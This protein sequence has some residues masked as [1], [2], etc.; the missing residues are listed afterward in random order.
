MNNKYKKYMEELAAHSLRRGNMLMTFLEGVP[1]FFQ[2]GKNLFM[3]LFLLAAA[4][5]RS[6]SA[7][8]LITTDKPDYSPGQYVIVTGTAWQPGETVRLIFEEYPVIHPADTLMVNADASGNFTDQNYLIE[9]H[10]LGQSF[11]LTATGL[12]SGMISKAYFTDGPPLDLDQ[13]HNGGIGDAPV[14]PVNWVNGNAHS[15]NSHFI[16]GQSI[17]YRFILQN[18][19]VGTHTVTIGWDIRDGGKSAIDYI[20]HYQ[21]I[22]ETVDPTLGL[23]G[24]WGDI[25]LYPI[26]APT[27]TVMV[28]AFYG[29]QPEP[30]YSFNQLPSAERLMTIYNAAIT[31]MSYDPEGDPTLAH[32]ETRLKIIFTVSGS[33]KDV[34]LAWGGH[35]A[36]RLEWGAI[37]AASDINGSPYH[38][39][40]VD[41]DGAGGSQDRSLKTDAVLF[42]PSC[43]VTGPPIVC[44]GSANSYTAITNAPTPTFTWSAIGGTITGSNTNSVVSVIAPASGAYTVN[45]LI[46]DMSGGNAS[47]ST[48]CGISASVSAAPTASAGPDQNKCYEGAN[49]SFTL[50]GS[51]SG[52]ST[53]SVVGG[54]AIIANAS[55][56][57]SAVTVSSASATLQLIAAGSNSNCS[58]ANDEV[59]LTVDPLPLLS[60][61][62][63]GTLTCSNQ[64][65]ALSG[66][67]SAGASVVWSGPGIVSGGNSVNPIINQPGVYK[68]IA[69]FTATGCQDSCSVNITQDIGSA[70]LSCGVGGTL[71][72]SVSSLTL[73]AT[74]G[75]DV[76]VVWNGPGIVSGGNTLNPVI[77]QPGDYKIIATKNS[78]GCKDSCVVHIY[79]DIAGPG[80][81]CGAG[82]TL[83]CGASSMT[84]SATTGSNVSVVW[85]GPGIVSGG[86]TLNPVIN[87]PGDYKIVATKNSSGCKDSCVVHIYQDIAG[88]GLSCGA[89]GTLT[90]GATSMTLSATTGSN[91]SVIWSGPGIVSGGNTLNPVI[92]QP[93]DY[94]IVATKN[95]SGCKD[96]CV[97]HIYQDIAGPALQCGSGGTLTCS[98]TSLTLSATTGSNVSVIWSGPGIVSGGNTLNP[99]IN[100]PG[101]YK[102]IATKNSSGCKDSCVVSVSQNTVQPSCEIHLPAPLPLC[103]STGNTLTAETQNAVSYTWT[104]DGD[105][106]AI[107]GG[108]GTQNIIYTS[109]AGENA[110]FKLVITGANGCKDS[111]LVT[112]STLPCDTPDTFCSLTQGFYGNAKGVACHTGE[113]GDVLINRL[114]GA[115]F[116]DLVIGKP[117]R[118]LTI[119]QAQ[120]A[121]ITMRLPAGGTAT[122]LPSGDQQFTGNCTTTVPLKKGKFNNVLLGQVIT[123]GLNMRFDANLGSL[124][125][126]GTEFTTIGVFEGPDGH[127]GTDDDLPN[128]SSVISRTIPQSVINALNSIYGNAT[129]ANLFDLANRALG[130]QSIG[131]STLNDINQAVSSI[132]EGFD[133]CRM[134]Q[135]WN[136][137]QSPPTAKASMLPMP[138]DIK[139]KAYPNPFDYATT[140]EFTA[141][142]D[143]DITLDVYSIDGKKVA[144]LYNGRV[145]SD[146][147]HK[148]VFNG[149]NLE[150]GIYFYRL[151]MGETIYFEKLM[152]TK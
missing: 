57:N 150:S 109:G 100:Q 82:G 151:T 51:A 56:L 47:E 17:P 130:G 48:T 13:G 98:A 34:L 141:T 46:V 104:V 12:T 42:Y 28:N 60:C 117:G 1:S 123:L 140:I 148:V 41:F 26:P 111:C 2:K 105:G 84:L 25:N 35:I 114:L 120:A 143:S 23:A 112:F 147:T 27:S 135:G 107:T 61:G 37:N 18:V 79:Q 69:T 91:V 129:V 4:F 138:S 53:W 142:T 22:S 44:A 99:V 102:I 70:G 146:E 52:V 30:L 133:G 10:D 3:I 86:N 21:R 58:N 89:G 68:M 92:N 108:Q 81:S 85:S 126:A 80:L 16:E 96:S 125:I 101:T 94:K 67:V 115:P 36:S 73:S 144:T 93:G 5:P 149:N 76:A 6:A 152:L 139:M 127:C 75:T 55:D 145:K 49:T 87:Q 29:N 134:L 9:P 116:G 95:S 78:S 113:R 62:N 19:S 45:V 97:V 103:S 132:N 71:T 72:C 106:W 8:G 11:T 33:A 136:V 32:S 43:N 74:T 83:T 40:I 137:L 63:G 119:T 110:T 65:L 15:G 7:Q 131:G 90:C 128:Y 50:A 59:I 122:L 39:R 77:N 124:V 66:S 38:T 64:T 88:P 20:T 121:C 14:S 54:S 118:S 31:S 24:S